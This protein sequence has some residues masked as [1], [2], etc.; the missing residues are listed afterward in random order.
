MRTRILLAL[1]V[2]SSAAILASVVFAQQPINVAQV[3][4]ATPVQAICDDPAKVTSANINLGAG[5]GNT[6]IVALSGT[7]VIYVCAYFIQVGGADGTQWI[8][9]TGSA[10]ASGETDKQT[11]KFTADGD[12]AVDNGGGMPLFKGA[13]GDALCVERT[14]SVALVGRVTYVQQ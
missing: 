11:F 14:S 2:M 8:T 4:G 9:G 12:G 13:A 6:E 5:T 7:T 1:F 10:C 3:N